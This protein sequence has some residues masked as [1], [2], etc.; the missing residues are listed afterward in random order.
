MLSIMM[1]MMMMTSLVNSII[2]VISS[3]MPQNS[4][5]N[6]TWDKTKCYSLTITKMGN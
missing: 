1:M 3:K 6:K 5:L 2:G 4:K